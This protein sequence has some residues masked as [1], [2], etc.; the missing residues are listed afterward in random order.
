MWDELVPY[1]LPYFRVLQYDTRGHGRS[2][3][4]PGPYSVD[5]LGQDVIDLLDQLKI[6]KVHFCGLSMGGLIGQWLGIHHPERLHK[7]IL[8]NTGSKIGTEAGWNE[9]I[10]TLSQKGMASIVEALSLIHI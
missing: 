6:D 4:T 3:Y 10:N 5:L 2:E 9:R 7:L 1:L 8:S